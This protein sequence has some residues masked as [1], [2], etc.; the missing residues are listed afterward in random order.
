MWAFIEHIEQSKKLLFGRNHG[1]KKNLKGK[2]STLK[3]PKLQSKRC[4]AA[5]L[6]DA[7]V[8]DD[9]GEGFAFH[10]LSLYNESDFTFV[11]SEFILFSFYLV[12]EAIARKLY[13]GELEM[14]V[15]LSERLLDSKVLASQD[16]DL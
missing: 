3:E 1:Y 9:G 7:A 13:L 16:L 2:I 15:R 14:S 11:E 5:A 12:M 10:A 6:H 8:A 4:L